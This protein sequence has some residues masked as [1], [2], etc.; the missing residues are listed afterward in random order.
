MAVI[1]KIEIA[2]FRCLKKFVWQP[3]PGINCL[4]GPGDSG[5]SSILDA[6]DYCLGAR[7]NLLVAD[8]DFHLLDV[9]NPINITVTLGKLD[10]A[11]KSIDAYGLYLKGFDAESG[12]VVEEPEAGLETVL[13]LEMTVAADLEPQWKLVSE[14]AAAQGHSRNLNW[15]D[16]QRIAPTRL[17]IFSEN[18]LSWRR[19]SILNRISE[20]RA[21]ASAALV[22][23]AR[24]MRN[25]FGEQAKE[26][27]A[28]ALQ[29]VTETADELGVPVG[30]EVKALL[31]AHSVSISG[32][33]ISLHD[34]RGVPLKALGLGSAR[35]LIAGLQRKGS[36]NCSMAIVDELE[37]GLEPHRIIRLIDALGAKEQNPPLQ[38]FITTHSP[39][40]VRELNGNQ[41]YVV[42]KV[43]DEHFAK[44]VG[45]ANDIRGTIRM[46]PEALLAPSIIVCEG[47]TEVGL[48]RGLDQYRT[49][50]GETALT[51]LGVGLVDGGGNNTFRRA[52]AFRSLGYRTA[53]LRDS[54]VAIAPL[55]ETRFREHG[56]TVFAWTQGRALE[57]ELFLS[58]SNEAV[59][60]L[61]D[62]AIR[63]KDESFI[64]ENIKSASAGAKDLATNRTEL[65]GDGITDE[66]SGVLA[67]AAKSGA[68]WY[69]S[70]TAMET[71]AREIIGPT[72]GD[73]TEAFIEKIEAIFDWM[74]DDQG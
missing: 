53:V 39:A 58:V 22:A 18:H 51:A 71:V 4:I 43:G 67:T 69:K 13:T 33:T 27:L 50:E 10:D 24:E 48:L 46:F 42:R 12:D 9:S 31:D 28:A 16:R 64:N 3:S 60:R 66:S 6:I 54:D 20:E 19:G 26:Q 56:G 70:I 23:A 7:R 52:N 32:G 74:Q 72:F 8:T 5:K 38:A 25:E 44:L 1:R 34:D 21:D 63:L 11:L 41:L 59:D 30:D 73:A 15:A 61:I 2:N 65:S 40:A 62:E 47:A 29:I 36:Q 57:D 45:T 35:L 17:G 55:A 68:G 14:R 37:H 49:A